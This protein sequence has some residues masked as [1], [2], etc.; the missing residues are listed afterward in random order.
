MEKNLIEK[1]EKMPKVELHLHLDGSIP[2]S[3]VKE[4][5]NLTNEQIENKMIASQKCKDLNDYLTCFDYPIS[6]MQ[7]KEEIKNITIELL[8]QLK[9]Q[10]VV[11]VEI[12]FAPQFH[13]RNGLTQEEVVKTVIEAKESVDIKSNLILC[14]MRGKDNMKQNYETIDIAKKY[15][16]KGVCAVDLAGA[17][18]LYKTKEYKK[19]FEYARENNI[20]FTIHAGEAD[21]AESVKSAIEFGAK[22]IGH[23]VRVI[24][25]AKLEEY[26]KENKIVLE[27]CPTSNIQTCICNS[28][29]TH[30]ISKL[31]G[32]GVLVTIN[33]DNM[34]VSN[35][36]LSNEYFNLVNETKIT[37]EDIN[38]MN[39]TA[40][41]AAFLTEEE[42][43]ELLEKYWEE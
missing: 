20:P 10:N 14:I 41:N 5:Y 16:G 30:P 36:N 15:L 23:G 26:I 37:L 28:Y 9:S 7:T 33:T 11:Y 43:K 22:R 32:D 18:A 42:K 3:Y 17:E 12:R 29:A 40:I 2:V 39:K 25:D 34:T 35:T 1:I 4:N 27:V 38:K 21:G 6:I 13:T 31:Y 19:I 8:K 24:E